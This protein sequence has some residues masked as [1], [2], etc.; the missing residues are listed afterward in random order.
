[1]YANIIKKLEAGEDVELNPKGNSMTPL[2]KSGERIVLSPIK[3]RLSI[4]KG[5]IVLARVNS[6]YYI[7]KVTRVV[8]W[9]RKISFQISNNHGY[10]NGWTGKVY[11]VVTEIG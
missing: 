4:K 3:D 9:N 1:M 7:H 5:D 11:G 6:N 10:I 8:K 2:I